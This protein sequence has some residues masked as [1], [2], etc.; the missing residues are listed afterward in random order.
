M[1][2]V[3][4]IV[5]VQVAPA[6]RPPP[7]SPTVDPPAAPV[8]VPPAQVVVA[9]G[10]AAIVMPGGNA[11]ETATAVRLEAPTPVL[12]IAIVSVEMPFAAIVGGENVLLNVTAVALPTV[13]VAVPGLVL[14]APCVLV[15]LLAGMVLTSL[16]TVL[17]VTLTVIVQDAFAPIAPA[18]SAMLPLPAV[19]V[20]VPPQV[21]VALG[22]AAIVRFA[23]NV[24][25]RPT[26]VSATEPA[27]V[28]AIPIVIVET[29][30]GTIEVGEKLLVIVTG[31]AT[32]K[33]AV[34]GAVLVEPSFVVT[35]EAAIVLTYAPAAVA[36]TFAENVQV[37][38]AASVPPVSPNEVAPATAVSV[39][40]QVV[41]PPGVAPIVTPKG[42][43][44]FSARPVSATAFAAVFAT[45]TVSVDVPFCG[46]VDGE[47]ALVTVTGGAIVS[48]AVAGPPLV[49]PCVLVTLLAGI[50]LT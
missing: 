24:S 33:V 12:A 49:A 3:T 9:F 2:P 44:S 15:M 50:V 8:T 43:P 13:S 17:D 28:L 4:A 32:V 20:N 25:V 42:S 37:A 29:P 26:P 22:V 41:T 14:V 27:A 5:I 18:A 1:A 48:V 46:I 47:N 40:P 35:A 19:A 11:S 10:V 36:V 34:A 6:A 21:V 45:V 31:G 39:P 38:P 16:P 23:G 7:V 30:P